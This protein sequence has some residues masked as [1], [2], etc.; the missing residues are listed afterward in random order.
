MQKTTSAINPDDPVMGAIWE[1]IGLGSQADHMML[2]R[3]S[4][5]LTASGGIISDE[6]MG[7]AITALKNALEA[8]FRSY[9]MVVLGEVG[10][11]APIPPHQ[12]EAIL[13]AI[14]PC[15]SRPS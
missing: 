14:E 13:A 8:A 4:A 7:W 1:Q 6:D 12:K 2:R 15:L 11:A 9:I 10:N 3:I 5:T